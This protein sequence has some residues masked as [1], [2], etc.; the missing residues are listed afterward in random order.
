MISFSDITF[1]RMK[2]FDNVINLLIN[3]Y[4]IN[5]WWIANINE[6]WKI[7]KANTIQVEYTKEKQNIFRIIRRWNGII[8]FPLFEIKWN[9][10]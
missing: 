8:K 2:N 10:Y 9:F 7:L 5:S 1:I 6:T 3:K 4:I